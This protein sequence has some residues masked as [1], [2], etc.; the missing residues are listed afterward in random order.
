MELTCSVG[1]ASNRAFAKIAANMKK[2]D[3]LT[4]IGENE[5]SAKL[6]PLS[7]SELTGV[8]AKSEKILKSMGIKTIGDL[9]VYPQNEL[10]MV[11][12]VNGEALSKLA[13]GEG[14]DKV[15]TVDEEEEIKSIGNE[16]TLQKDTS[17]ETIIK[18]LLLKL[19]EKVGRR[20][21]ES[22]FAGRIVTIKLRYS[23]FSTFTKR[24]TTHLLIWDDNKIYSI[25][26]ELFYSVY[27]K[28]KKIRL[29]GITVSGLIKAYNNNNNNEIQ[30]ELF[31]KP[32][33][34]ETLLKTVD[35]LKDTY[36]EKVITRAAYLNI[37]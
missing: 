31:S 6:Y 15:L 13:R 8:G 5:K 22:G 30:T 37:F 23:D 17:N 2:P 26:K 12:G 24:K 11:F 1:I 19:S 33:K 20:L 3:G 27:R 14:S 4:I 29:I 34:N 28:V 7:V 9:A 10:K 18:M 16:H 25:S 36:G 32:Q 35:L 21:R